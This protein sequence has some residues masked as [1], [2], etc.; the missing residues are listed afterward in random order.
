LS[1]WVWYA[2]SFQTAVICVVVQ[3]LTNTATSSK[4]EICV[5]RTIWCSS[6][7]LWEKQPN[8]VKHTPLH[9]A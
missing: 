9:F 1:G 3:A 5:N 7:T 8:N 4:N 6:L 2:G